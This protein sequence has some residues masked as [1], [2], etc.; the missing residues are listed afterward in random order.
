MR[1][2]QI[3][4]QFYPAIGGIESVVWYLSKYLQQAGHHVDI[5]TINQ[6]FYNKECPLPEMEIVEGIRIYRIPFW[7]SSRYAIAPIVSSFLKRYDLIHLHSSDFFLDYLALTKWFHQVPIVLSTHGYYFHTK[8]A[9]RLK[10]MYF[11][12]VT[13]F[14]LRAVSVV[15]CDSEQDWNRAA[16]VVSRGKLVQIPNGVDYQKLVSFSTSHRRGDLAI[17]VGRF[18]KNKGYEQLLLVFRRV[19]MFKPEVQ[20]R[21]LGPDC[22]MLEML[23][24]KIDCY[25]LQNNVQILESVSEESLNYYLETA[26]IWLSASTYES[27]GIALLEAMAAGCVPIVNRLAVF[28][29]LVEDKVDGF[30]V[31]FEN[32]EKTASLIVDVLNM[33]KIQR[34]EIV[35]AARAKA[36]QFS[37]HAIV[38]EFETTFCEVVGK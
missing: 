4:R 9:S 25:G 31:S 6:V 18:V 30:I 8:F 16:S 35:F 19:V 22:G 32:I 20:L 29:Q 12:T 15:I 11:Q 34:D 13:R 28:E 37:W 7:G 23:Q 14:A 24:R 36:A 3:T 5:I 27:F 33:P 38:K 1:L 10:R 17:S 26:V 2:V 21:I